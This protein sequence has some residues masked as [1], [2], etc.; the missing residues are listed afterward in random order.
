[1]VGIIPN[2]ASRKL[3]P[4]IN[5]KTENVHTANKGKALTLHAMEAFGGRG[6]IAPTHS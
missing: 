4:I 2:M 3:V 1:M 6:G 5:I